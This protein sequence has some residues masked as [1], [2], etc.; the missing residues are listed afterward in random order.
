MMRFFIRFLYYFF[1]GWVLYKLAKALFS[2]RRRNIS[3]EKF[4]NSEKII[5][6]GEFVKDPNCNV[7]F[8][9]EKAI[10]LNY[11]GENYYFCSEECKEKFLGHR[12]KSANK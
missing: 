9:K 7:F 2:N 5:I 10:L 6:G 8:P 3:K 4:E 12:G 1:L 11:K